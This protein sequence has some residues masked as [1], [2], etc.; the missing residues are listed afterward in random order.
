MD[1][2]LN[3]FKHIATFVSPTELLVI[4]CAVAAVAFFIV[5]FVLGLMGKKGAFGGLM[6]G[7]DEAIKREK[8]HQLLN[9]KLSALLAKDEFNSVIKKFQ[10]E[11]LDTIHA[12]NREQTVKMSEIFTKVE[13]ISS[14]KRDV[15]STISLIQ[16]DIRAIRHQM[17]MHDMTDEKNFA[18]VKDGIQRAQESLNRVM[19]QVEK[20]DEFAR[21]MVPEFRGHHKDLNS[22]LAEISKD[23]ALVER[24]IQT[25][26]S[27]ANAVTLR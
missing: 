7:D 17:Q 18:S 22:A 20:I 16:E 12:L 6:G 11:L 21:A 14:I 9:D 8:M 10:E 15:D 5:K 1:F 26:I 3:I 4:I 23:I 25:Q 2:V 27:T 19:I 24:S 13:M